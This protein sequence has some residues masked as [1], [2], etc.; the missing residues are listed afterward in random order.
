[1]F[2]IATTEAPRDEFSDAIE[3]LIDAGL[4]VIED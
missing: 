3:V 4:L 2:H 1:M